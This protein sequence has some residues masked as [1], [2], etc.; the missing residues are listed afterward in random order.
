MKKILFVCLG[1]ICRSP[2]AEAIFR[3]R[4]GE[5]SW[6]R[7]IVCDSAGT[8]EWHQG[9]PA[10]ERMRQ[11]AAIHGISIN[12][13]SRQVRESDFFEFDIIVAMDRMNLEDLQTMNLSGSTASLVLLRSF[14]EAQDLDVPDP[15][16]S[17]RDGF[18]TCYQ[19]VSDAI[20]AFIPFLK[21]SSE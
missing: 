9:E 10:D 5:Y 17:A 6:G 19:I 21:D 7:D 14:N 11:A 20:D 15:Y 4:I 16:Y 2:L 12:S 8:S 13:I 1:N 18:E 3:H